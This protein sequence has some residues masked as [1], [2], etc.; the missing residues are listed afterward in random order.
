MIS[1]CL[2][3]VFTVSL[4]VCFKEFIKKNIDTHQAITFNYLTACA[5][6]CISHNQP[7]DMT[8]LIN[9]N[10]IYHTIFL[11]IFFVIMFN[12]MGKTTQN[13]GVSIASMSSKMSLIIPA[14]AVLLY[15]PNIELKK[16]TIFG[17]LLAILSVYLTFK[18]NNDQKKPITLAIILF[19][20]AGILDSCLAYINNILI[21]SKDESQ[22]FIIIIFFTAFST[23]LLKILFNKKTIKIKNVVAGVILGIPNY[24]SIY[25]VLDSLKNL[26]ETVVF[27]TLNIGVVLLAT[28]ISVSF[29]NEKLSYTNWIG[30]FLACLSIIL[31]LAL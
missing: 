24:F 2:T 16:T 4:F 30:V 20:G 9:Y 29:Y 6:A 14:L 31:I 28:I 22:K 12:I 8:Q 19:F 3:I 11:G 23:G 26:G 17:V 21:A 5:I 1:L 18:K 25:F 13:L 15:D 27:P 7:I 10:W